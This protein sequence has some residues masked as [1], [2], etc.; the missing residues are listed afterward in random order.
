MTVSAAGDMLSLAQRA[1]IEP[2]L[3]A[4]WGAQDAPED[5]L[6]DPWFANLYLFRAAHRWRLVR[7]AH[8]CIEGLAYDGARLLLPLFDL[9]GA[10]VGALRSLLAGSAFFAPLS[11]AQAARLDPDVF[12]LSQSRADADYLYRADSFRHYRGT[13][14]QKKRNL[15]KQ[16]MAEHA[17]EALRYTGSLA[18]A[19][20]QV[21]QGWLDAKG[22]LAGEADDGPCREALALAEPLGLEGW[23]F[24][25]EGRP[26]GFVLAQRIRPGVAVMRFAKASPAFNGLY[27]H[28]F[29]HHVRSD[30][31]LQWLNFEQDLGLAN[32]RQT[33]MSYRPAA[34]LSKHRVSIRG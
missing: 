24:R 33:K 18:D 29:Q 21:L 6:S 17:V 30:P 16:L 14:L 26:A 8:P 11:D 28:M 32:F 12:V 22:R 15:V 27:Q 4:R 5:T 3:R 1:E 7:G 9:Q 10:P 13:L 2:L 20:A 23:L 34:L 25:I 31:A 19:A